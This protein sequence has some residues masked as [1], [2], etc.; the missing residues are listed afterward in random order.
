METPLLVSE[1]VA[2]S[3]EPNFSPGA[4]T[5]RNPQERRIVGAVGVSTSWMQVFQTVTRP[6]QHFDIVFSDGAANGKKYL[7]TPDYGLKLD[8]TTTYTMRVT[9]GRVAQLGFGARPRRRTGH[10]TRAGRGHVVKRAAATEH[11]RQ[12]RLSSIQW[13]GTSLCTRAPCRRRA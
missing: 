6:H 5:N 8:N 12:R 4:T 11:A 3:F 2:P 13:N 7:W 1:V 10:R 9:A